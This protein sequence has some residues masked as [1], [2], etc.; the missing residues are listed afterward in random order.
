[1][2][3]ANHV[4]SESAFENIVR[5]GFIKPINNIQKVPTCSASVGDPELL[6]D[7]SRGNCVFFTIQDCSGIFDVHPSPDYILDFDLELL[8]EKYPCRVRF[9]E[10]WSGKE[11]VENLN[12]LC[13]NRYT[14]EGVFDGEI[15]QFIANV[16]EHLPDTLSFLELVIPEDVSLEHVVKITKT[17]NLE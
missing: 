2:Y 8:L 13:D 9:I 11:F 15:P 16:E 3:Y 10:E 6:K 5:D 7:S 4:T 14:I 12:S 1:M 17:D